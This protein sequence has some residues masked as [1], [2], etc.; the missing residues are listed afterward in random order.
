MHILIGAIILFGGLA[1]LG[2]SCLCGGGRSS[3]TYGDGQRRETE[4]DRRNALM[5]HYYT[6]S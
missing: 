6:K 4:E 2:G 5:Q 1:L 3:T